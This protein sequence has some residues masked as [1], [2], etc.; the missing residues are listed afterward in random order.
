MDTRDYLARC[1]RVH[2]IESD[3]ALAK[4]L[5]VSRQAVSNWQRGQFTLGNRD[6][7]KVAE[8]LGMDPALIIADMEAERAERAGKDD[9]ATWWREARKKL[10]QVLA[11]VGIAGA[12]ISGPAPSEA[13]Q[14][15]D[16]RA[17]SDASAHC[18]GSRKRRRGASAG[19]NQFALA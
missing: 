3:Y 8:L 13:K 16:L 15:N 7:Y 4:L 9:D 1:K 6:C 10:L 5:G 17:S 2:H 11:I 14:I 19:V 12:G 18:R